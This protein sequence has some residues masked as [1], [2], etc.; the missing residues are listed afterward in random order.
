M[1]LLF[2]PLGLG[3]LLWFVAWL[4]IRRVA[5]RHP[6][7]GVL[8]DV[9]DQQIHAVIRGKDKP[10]IPVVLIH[11]ASGNVRDQEK[12]VMD[13][14][15]NHHPVIA[16]DRPGFGW[17][18]RPRGGWTDPSKQAA[19]LRGAFQK[20]G[21]KHAVIVG[22]SYGASLA[23][24]WAI[25]HPG[26]VAG[27]VSLSGAT[28]PYD[29]K[30]ATYRRLL[31]VPVLGSLFAHLVGPLVGPFIAPKMMDKTF[32]PETPPDNYA[33]DIGVALL[34][35]PRTFQYDAQD[36]RNLNGWLHERAKDWTKIDVPV[37]AIH[38]NRDPI[39]GY[40]INAVPIGERLKHGRFVKLPGAGHLPHHTQKE[41]VTDLITS[42]ADECG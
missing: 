9:G 39:T 40:K 23:L 36:V 19:L 31:G 38:G 7:H 32:W 12:G 14:L 5:K 35:Q 10:G 11:G 24:A 41:V 34:F 2:V 25:D 30:T 18:T 13:A 29:T 28:H 33:E 8:I 4:N 20:L 21:Y 26:S 17:S 1:T 15:A 42:F 27:V 37:L 22:H 6:A 3:A 16:F